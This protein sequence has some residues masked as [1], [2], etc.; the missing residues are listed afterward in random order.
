MLPEAARKVCSATLKWGSIWRATFQAMAFSTSKRR[1]ELGG[2]CEGLRHAELVDVENL[3][4]YGDAAIVDGVAAD[5]DV[6]GVEGLGDADGGG[7]GGAEVDGEAEVIESVLAV[8]AGDG[9]EA[10]GGK[11]LVEGV[12]EGVA[13]PGEVG[14]AG[15]VVEGK[16]EDDVAVGVGSFRVWRGLG[17]SEE[18]REEEQRQGHCFER[19]RRSGE[20]LVTGM[21]IERSGVEG[22]REGGL[23]RCG[24]SGGRRP[25]RLSL[26]LPDDVAVEQ[27]CDLGGREVAVEVEVFG[28]RGLVA[29]AEV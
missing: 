1:G 29:P 2:V 10:G 24:G 16:D 3:G 12:G 15:A 4:L 26:G 9:E 28:V 21:S 14:L 6:V 7:A 19:S 25:T 11:A 17:E 8:V 5:D 22:V 27:G 23:R 13:D 18:E 20:G